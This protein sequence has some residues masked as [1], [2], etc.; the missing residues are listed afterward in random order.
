MPPAPD[1]PTSTTPLTT[2][3]QVNMLTDGDDKISPATFPVPTASPGYIETLAAALRTAGQSVADTGNDI[4]SSWGALTSSYKAPEADELYTVLGPVAR[5]GDDVLTGLNN[6]ANALENFA[7]DLRGIKRRW[8][9]LRTEAYTF[10]ARIDAKGDDWR[11]AEGVAGFFGIG[12]SPDV[13]ENS[14]LIS[15]GTG[16]IEDYEAAERD[17]ANQINHYVPDRTGFEAMPSGGGELDP[18][19]FYH[20]YEDSLSDLATEWDMGGATTDEHWWVDAGAAVWDFGVGAV[21]GTGAMLGMH[22][23]EGWFQAS[24][25]DALW[26]YH[27]G[28]VQSVASLVGMYDGESDSWGWAGG[29]ALGSA[30]KDLAHSVVPWEEW[31]ERPGYVI[32]TAALNIVAMVGGAA[33]TATGVG[34]VVG[35]P[36]MAWRGMAIVD[37]MGGRGGGSGSGSGT[38]VDVDLPAGIPNYGGLNS[39]I[40]SL[41]ASSFDRGDYSPA[42]WTELQTHL[43]R[44]ASASDSG[45]GSSDPGGRPGAPGRPAQP[46]NDRDEQDPARQVDPTAQQLADGEAFWDIV[47][48]PDLA[49]VDRAADR[50]NQPRIQEVARESQTDPNGPRGSAEGRWTAAELLDGPEG[51]GDRV[52]AGVGGRGDDTLTAERDV[53]VS[54]PDRTVNLTDGT[55]R[56]SD[57]DRVGERDPRTDTDARNRPGD[58]PENRRDVPN[59]RHGADMRDRN[60]DVRNSADGGDPP[61]RTP[62][63][64]DRVDARID[65]RTSP[66]DPSG[67]SDTDGAS[68]GSRTHNDGHDGVSARPASGPDSPDLQRDGSD[69]SGDADSRSS[70][71]DNGPDGRQ[72]EPLPVPKTREEAQ[73]RARDILGTMD[74]GTGTD[75]RDNFV[76]LVNDKKYGA[77]LERAFYNTLGHRYREGLSINGQPIPSLTRADTGDPWIARDALPPPEAPFYL[78]GEIKGTRAGITIQVLR[79]LDRFAN[80]RQISLDAY[81]PLNRIVQGLKAKYA[82]TPS[83][84]VNQDLAR[85]REIRKP[86]GRMRTRLTERFGDKSAEQAVRDTFNGSEVTFEEPLRNPDGKPVKDSEGKVVTTTWRGTLPELAESEPGRPNPIPVSDNAPKNGNHQFDQIWRTADGGLVIVEAKSSLDTG[87]NERT[88]KTAD[89]PKRVQ[90][91]TREYFND[92]LKRMIKRG[93]EELE[94]ALEI[95]DM[96]IESPEKLHYVE[97]K[98]DPDKSGKYRGNS[99]KFFDIREEEE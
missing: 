11:D 8:N 78:P 29:D 88:I 81:N 28:N 48:Q 1:V 54:P 55:G 79:N 30:W 74:L 67:R 21:E 85:A 52:P 97:A 32:G 58:G 66:L 10:R 96:M 36:L 87:L 56:G 71:A 60:P 44:W 23:S 86:M 57:G 26:E 19:V 64:E 68:S 45:G 82:N 99:M 77:L 15:E 41:D 5:D 61:K 72:E 40:A 70:S 89:G 2:D 35:V 73:A 65:A 7:E 98:G 24:W 69:G 50:D 14:R 92:I 91:G 17:C 93:G 25:G 38:N 6:A 3:E 22:S 16:I 63:G 9:S 31:G 84:S 47:E 27:E 51:A 18:D 59:D 4:D 13:E 39:P 90:Q 62:S 95:Q 46:R 49:E 33:L 12:E 53:P 83:S 75:F 42:Q 20:G 43:D 34:A 76:D 80:L 37:G 94:L